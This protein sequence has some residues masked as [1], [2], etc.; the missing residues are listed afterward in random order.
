MV[1]KASPQ[2]ATTK[3][4]ASSAFKSREEELRKYLRYRD[5]IIAGLFLLLLL[6]V[7]GLVRAPHVIDVY[8]PPDPRYGRLSEPNEVPSTTVYG[9]ASYIFTTLQT[10]DHDGAKDYE[11][12]RFNLRAFLTPQYQKQIKQDIEERISSGELR[13][14][15][16]IVTMAP[17]ATFSE[18]LV[19]V[20]GPDTWTVFLDLRVRE[21]VDNRN[22][23]DIYV[24]Y[25]LRV[26]RYDISREFNPWRLALDGYSSTPERLTF[27]DEDS[28]DN[29][30]DRKK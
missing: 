6:A 5:R 16:R 7:A 10:W 17:G 9:F 27:G 15:T 26:V 23:K 4:K 3:P 19:K 25:P 24:R 22:V 18:R 8:Q 21:F 2:K 28:K 30:T 13:G 29:G 11:Q 20:H 12:N 1:F 14:R